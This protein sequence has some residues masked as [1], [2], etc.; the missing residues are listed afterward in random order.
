MRFAWLSRWLSH[1]SP[2]TARRPDTRIRLEELEPRVLLNN[3]F[4]L[5]RGS[6]Q[7]QTSLAFNWFSR[8]AAFNNELG[9]YTVTDD[10][11]F[12]I[13]VTNG[14]GVSLTGLPGQTVPATFTLGGTSTAF[15]NELGVY[16]V[17]SLDGKIGTLK[18]GDAGWINAALTSASHKVLFTGDQA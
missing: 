3:D 10:A 11:V 14:G 5:V 12:T 9:V 8:D 1:K 4:Y 2:R 15:H 13:T 7:Q 17:D 6:G 18:P 16:A